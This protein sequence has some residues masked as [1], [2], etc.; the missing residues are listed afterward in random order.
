MRQRTGGTPTAAATLTVPI[1]SGAGNALVATIAVQAGT[2]TKVSVVTDSAGNAWTLGPG[3]P[4]GRART[5]GSRSWHSTGA[6]PVAGVTVH[7]S[8]ADLASA[9]VS[10]WSGVATAQAVDAFAGPGNASS[11]TAATPSIATT[12][13][14]DLVLGAINFPRAVYVHAG[15]ARL[16][17]ARRLQRVD[18]QRT[19]G[20]PGRLRHRQPLALHGHCRQRRP[21]ARRAGPEGGTVM[22]AARRA[23]RLRAATALRCTGP[24]PADATADPV[25]AAAGDIGCDPADP[26]YNGGAGTS[27]RCRQRATSDLLVGAGLAAVLPLGRHPVRQPLGREDQRRLRRRAGAGSSRSAGRCSATTTAPGPPTST[28]SMEPGAADGPAGPRGRGYYSYDVGAWHL[29]ALNS[30][31]TRVSCGAGSIQERWLRADLAAH[32]AACTLAYWH[33]PRYSSGHDGS[34]VTLHPLWK[35]LDDAG[36]ELLLTGHSHN[37]E[38]FAPRDGNGKTRAVG[39]REFVVGTGGAFMTGLGSA[40]MPGSEA[41]QNHTFGV[42]KVTLHA[43]SYDWQFAPVAGN[44]WSDSGSGQ[45]HGPAG[46]PLVPPPPVPT[47][48]STRP[49]I[50]NLRLAPRRFRRRTVFHYTLS[51]AASVRFGIARRRSGARYRR[52]GKFAQVGAQGRNVRPFRC[53]IGGRRLRAGRFRARVVARDS[54]GNYS[55]PVI[56]RFR[57]AR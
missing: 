52:V 3:G 25:I 36:V 8:A 19:R 45:C 56:A 29:V 14:N 51:E 46:S 17:G 35:A 40:R 47:I 5:R 34:H 39:I 9:N 4:P 31:C 55:K 15:D 32:P 53:V 6:A 42:L 44:T 16:H 41:A 54:A 12:N 13:A 24:R 33:H 7:L 30:N 20:V 23:A 11:T 22:R 18:R 28:T 37:Y 26:G 21:A 2:T 49:R 10:E 57:I 43:L 27:T 48:D 50:M 38:R 1:A